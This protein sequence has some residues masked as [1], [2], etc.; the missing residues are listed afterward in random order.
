MTK[1]RLYKSKNDRVIAGVCGGLASYFNLDPVFLRIL[2]IVLV[3]CFGVGA[4]AYMILWL[5]MPKS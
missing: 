1:R 5:V 2:W 3:L 4:V